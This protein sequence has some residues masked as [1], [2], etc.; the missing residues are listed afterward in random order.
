MKKNDFQVPIKE[1]L[2]RDGLPKDEIEMVAVEFGLNRIDIE[3]D[4]LEDFIYSDPL[5]RTKFLWSGTWGLFDCTQNYRAAEILCEVFEADPKNTKEWID[6][7]WSEE[8]DN[9]FKE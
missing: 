8:Y 2:E 7:L 3:T 1:L 6:Y 5:I 9:Q 4:S